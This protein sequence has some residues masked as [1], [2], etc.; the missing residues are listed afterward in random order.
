MHFERSR[1]AIGVLF[2]GRFCHHRLEQLRPLLRQFDRRDW[3]LIR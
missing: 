3:P 1:D 2:S